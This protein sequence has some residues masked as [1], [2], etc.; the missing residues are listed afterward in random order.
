[1]ANG[2]TAVVA[3]GGSTVINVLGNDTDPDGN[4][5]IDPATVEVISGPANGSTSV[6]TATGQITYTSDGAEGVTADS[7]TY[8]VKDA[9][10]ALSNTATVS[11]TV[12]AVNDGPPV[13]NGD[14]AV[15]AEGG[16]TVI[17]VLGNDTDPDGNATIDPATVEVISGPA[18]GSTSVNTTT[19]QITYTSNGA[20]VTS[21][22]F[23]YRV[24]DANGAVSN[25]A[26]VTVTV[27]AV[28]DGP[29]V[30]N[31]D[32]AVVAE[33]GSTVI[34]VL[35]NDTDPDGNATIDPA[36]VEVISG[37]ANGSTSV[38]TT[39]GQ[40]TYTSNGAEVTSDSF[41]YR[42][43]DANGAV[44]NTATVSITVN[45]VNDAPVVT[46]PPTVGTPDAVTGKVIGSLGINDPEG[47]NT[48]SYHVTSQ[49]ASGTVTFANG[50]YTYTPDP[51][52]RLDA[53]ETP[54][55]NETVSFTVE[56]SDG[57]SAPVSVTVSSVPI[58]PAEAVVTATIP[59]G[60]LPG[61]VAVS[62]DGT[63]AY[64]TDQTNG[65]VSVIDTA[66]NTVIATIPVGDASSVAVRV[67]GPSRAY[68]TNRNSDTVSVIDTAT[69]TVIATI[70]V[71]DAPVG[72]AVNPFFAYVANSGSD[73]VSVINT[74]DNTVFATIPVGDQPFGVAVSPDF[75]R[76]YVTNRLGGTVS[77]IDP[78]TNS[79]IATI[80]VG[81]RPFGVAVSSD[82]AYVT[83]SSGGTVSVID[84]A[85]NAVIA[86]IP[87]RQP[88]GR[89]GGQPG[90]HPRLRHQSGRRYGIGDRHCH[91]HRNRNCSCRR[92]IVR[93]TARGGGQP[94]WLPRLCH[95]SA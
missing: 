53:Y 81:D 73:S 57:Q 51:L 19:G 80:P 25:T 26:T 46:G 33:G 64:I 58:D 49:P 71:G 91:Q 84:T 87:C 15:V 82:S 83:N 60:G 6:N 48:L 94:R 69:D 86:T 36:T 20:E 55:A 30:A 22:S 66:T 2:D 45:A 14:T 67:A 44:S 68:V 92:H 35:G 89:C 63:R 11:V 7:F 65:T 43:K 9:S 10:G 52:A 61:G 1:M 41:T 28:N 76:V 37:P 17:N 32:T 77:V 12:N 62:R 23:T 31:G 75:T 54:N 95:E 74:F 85:T 3:E 27:A 56:V 5:T 93:G 8:R 18:N 50:N 78:L 42:V 90:G 59:V 24:K 39:T 38:N 88:T 70:S 34:N 4:A 16:S 47:N 13:A 72:V 29:P 79:V 40:I 21:D